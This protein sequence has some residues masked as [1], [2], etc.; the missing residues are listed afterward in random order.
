MIKYIPPYRDS[1]NPRKE[2]KELLQKIGF[3]VIHCSLRDNCYS[4]EN[5]MDWNLHYF[6]SK[7]FLVYFMYTYLKT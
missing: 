2:L 1:V 4:D 6:T 7:S 5:E 3:T